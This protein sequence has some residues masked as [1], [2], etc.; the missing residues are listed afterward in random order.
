MSIHKILTLLFGIFGS[1]FVLNR[2][3]DI[4]DNSDLLILILIIAF[5]SHILII[6]LIGLN[7]FNKKKTTGFWI[8]LI[9]QLFILLRHTYEYWT[10]STYKPIID[11]SAS[12]LNQMTIP[13]LD[14]IFYFEL[15]TGLAATTLL[16]IVNRKWK[17]ANST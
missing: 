15:A 2:F 11:I 1:F 6:L 5:S 13:Y 17:V 12:I 8:L 3:Y 4:L 10:I 16:F 7:L 9:F 14:F